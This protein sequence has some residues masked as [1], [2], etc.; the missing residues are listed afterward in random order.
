MQKEWYWGNQQA[1]SG[2]VTLDQL[3]ELVVNG[4]IK[5]N[6]LVGK[7]GVENWIPANKVEGLFP[8]SGN[9]VP[10]QPSS[11]LD[12]IE[13]LEDGPTA[14][15][16]SGNDSIEIIEDSEPPGLPQAPS[17]DEPQSHAQSPPAEEEQ[18]EGLFSSASSKLSGFWGKAKEKIN[19]VTQ[20]GNS[21]EDCGELLGVM[22]WNHATKIPEYARANK[23]ILCAK[24]VGNYDINCQSCGTVWRLNLD[25]KITSC[26]TCDADQK[27]KSLITHVYDEYRKQDTWKY[28]FVTYQGGFMASLKSVKTTIVKRK[29]RESGVFWVAIKVNTKSVLGDLRYLDIN[30]LFIKKG[31]LVVRTE[32]RDYKSSWVSPAGEKTW[33]MY[34]SMISSINA[35]DLVALVDMEGDYTFRLEGSEFEGVDITVTSLALDGVFRRFVDEHI[36]PELKSGVVEQSP[37]LKLDGEGSEENPENVPANPTTQQKEN[38]APPPDNE[39]KDGITMLKELKELLEMG[40]LTQ[41]EFD[42]KKA[43][44]L[45][46]M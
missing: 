3:R 33:T 2:P 37:D 40:V 7:H 10:P 44:I 39:G 29:S 9:I 38:P 46:R 23:Q 15:P 19:E 14:A 32:R 27:Y 25:A 28:A 45:N 42:A 13:I 24:C 26:P 18:A 21:C 17:S 5:P 11:D 6:D 12:S 41:E 1:P 36:R 8:Y 30:N 4:G 22:K 31:K 20:S 34:E 43:D 35:S 16:I